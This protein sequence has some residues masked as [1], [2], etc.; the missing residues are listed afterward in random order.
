[1]KVLYWKD[2]V[3]YRRPD[4]HP[5]VK[6]WEKVQKSNPD[7]GYHIETEKK[8]MV[9]YEPLRITTKGVSYWRGRKI[10]SEHL[11]EILQSVILDLKIL[12][13]DRDD[14]IEDKEGF[15]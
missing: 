1:M 2:K 6:D 9:K 10:R 15:G 11:Q 13:D 12:S 4:N 3:I 8:V 14:L 7:L 5:D